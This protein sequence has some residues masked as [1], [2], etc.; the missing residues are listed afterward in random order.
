MSQSKLSISPSFERGDAFTRSLARS[1]R[2][3]QES[4]NLDDTTYFLENLRYVEPRFGLPTFS[5][6]GAE[7]VK[8]LSVILKNNGDMPSTNIEVDL[9]FKAYGTVNFYPRDG[10]VFEKLL[11]REV[12]FEEKINIRVPYIGGNEERKYD[13][14]SLN[15]QFRET[16]LHLL[17]IRA[18]S[19]DYIKPNYFKNLFSKKDSEI[20]LHHY[21]CSF[22]QSNP[23][24][25]LRFEQLYGIAEDFEDEI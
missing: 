4:R 2:N 12:F 24:T 20:I 1:A 25:Q 13:I 16:E 19:F 6:N 17:K 10:E 18:N 9:V 8:T 5:L 23:M 3:N 14:C 22:L 21:K 15:G 7:P 11:P